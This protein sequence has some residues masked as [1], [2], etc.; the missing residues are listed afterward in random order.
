MEKINVAELLRDCPSGME[1]DCTMYDNLHFDKV[2]DYDKNIHCY[3]QYT[4]HR[5][6][7]MFGKDGTYNSE[8]ASKCVIFP[9]GKTTWEGF[10][11]PC[12]FKDG[13]IVVSSLGNIHILKN[14]I[15]SYIYVDFAHNSKGWLCK[16]LTTCVNVIRLATE[17]EKAKLFK[18]IK[19]NGYRWN[20]ETKT[21]EKLLKFKVGDRIRH[22]CPEFRGERI[23]NICC[24]MGYF[25]TIN[26]WIDIAHQDDW[27]LVSEKL[28][29]PKFKDGDI[30]FYDNCVSIFK[31]WGDE[32]LFRNYVKVDID[33]RHP[34]L[35]DRTHSNGKGIKREARFATKEEKVKLFQVIRD[36]GYK[37]NPKAKTLENLFS[38]NMGQ[39]VWVKSDKERKY[40]HTIVGISRNSFGNLE[41]EVK[42]EKSGVVVHYPESLLIPITTKEPRF[43]VGDTI[44]NGKISITIGYIDD[45]Y[46]YEVS[47]NIAHRLF[48][49]NQD[50]WNLVPDKFNLTTLVPF[51]SRVLV[52][53]DK[54]SYWR[55]SIFGCYIKD[56][57]MPYYVLGGTCWRYCIPYE[58]NE[59]L[60]GKTDD[61][62]EYFK[63][64]E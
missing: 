37:W 15:T 39:K 40:I 41:Y 58:G 32:T 47:R 30:V 59:H 53:N 10:T 21:L 26:D 14:R 29:E 55:P 61:C 12:Q 13:D 54:D 6:H 19:D 27:E 35:C 49:E 4:D 44:T 28:V 1:L 8:K 33:G 42:E 20:E 63:T 25:T 52:R 24:D 43:K 45:K 18:V 36:N 31:E 16:S 46:Y 2:D 23:V 7:I 57:T 22:K 3:I 48:I 17:E 11:P 34:M 64:W 5:T 62:K 60:R 50:E 38:Y 51:E 56:M 9:K